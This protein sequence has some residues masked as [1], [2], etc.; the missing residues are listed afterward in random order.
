MPEP[1][2]K[3]PAIEK[4]LE[5]AFGRTSAI[6]SATCV[7]APAGCGGPAT[8]FRNELSRR[9]YAISGLCQ[10]CQDSVFGT[11]NEED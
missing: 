10:N 7:P 6:R 2:K 3:N 8:E 9:E 1:S 5:G 11:D 4:F